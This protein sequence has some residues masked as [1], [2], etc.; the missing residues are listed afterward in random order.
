MTQRHMH[1]ISKCGCV[2]N[3]GRVLPPD[4]P[5]ALEFADS[6]QTL[7]FPHF[8]FLSSANLHTQTHQH[9]KHP[10]T[11][12]ISSPIL[13]E[14][15]ATGDVT[16]PTPNPTLLTHRVHISTPSSTTD[17]SAEYM[18]SSHAKTLGVPSAPNVQSSF[19]ILR[20]PRRSD[21]EHNN[22]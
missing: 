18:Y 1:G 5:R 4:H 20:R 12:N 22:G 11:A 6:I 10:A 13:H 17:E 14:T 15:A 9:S 16:I 21:E 7:R 8:F 19:R 3:L 2:R